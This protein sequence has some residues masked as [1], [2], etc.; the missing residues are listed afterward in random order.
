MSDPTA[1][2]TFNRRRPTVRHAR[3]SF[4]AAAAA[5][6]GLSLLLSLSPV[7]GANNGNGGGGNGGG[8]GAAN[9][10]TVK[11]HDADT[12]LETDANDNDPHV[13]DFWLGFHFADTYEAGSWAVVSSA[14]TGDGST[15][16]SGLYDT[17]GDGVDQSDVL[18]LDPGHYRVEWQANGAH[19]SKNKVLWVD[20]DCD[21]DEVTEPE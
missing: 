9:S 16:A 8:G 1:S 3:A 13:C 20:E 19:S 6:F 2:T 17:S 15:V 10:G 7:L 5:V 4:V 21:G 14:P 11:V 12:G 18:S